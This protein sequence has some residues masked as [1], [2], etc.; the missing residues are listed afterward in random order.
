MMLVS[1]PCVFYSLFPYDIGLFY[2]GLSAAVAEDSCALL[3]MM[4]VSFTGLFCKRDL[5]F[6]GP[7][8]K[9]MCSFTDDV[10]LFSMCL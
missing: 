10:G 7:Y 1:F 6:E 4:L 3:Q 5:S 8:G 2:M 9:F